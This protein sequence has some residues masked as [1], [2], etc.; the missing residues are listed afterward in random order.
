M[1]LCSLFAPICLDRPIYPCRTLCQAV[2][3]GC[4]S[5]MR[6]Y[7]FPWPEMLRC[8]KFP[9]DNDLCVGV[10]HRGEERGMTTI[11]AKIFLCRVP[12]GSKTRISQLVFPSRTSGCS[13]NSE[14]P[15]WKY[16]IS[17]FNRTIF[18]TGKL[19]NTS[20][21]AQSNATLYP[22]HTLQKSAT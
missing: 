18:P 7:G 11:F 2:Q 9:L 12:L 6:N 4:E 8:D 22:W 21:R 14:F 15:T 1:F 13:Q 17:D 3:T 20:F 10:Q 16:D 19:L 5:R